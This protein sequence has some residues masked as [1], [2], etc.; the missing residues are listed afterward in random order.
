MHKYILKLSVVLCVCVIVG[1]HAYAQIDDFRSID[2]HK[3]DSMALLFPKYPL[4][5]LRVLAERL[6]GPL[7]TEPEKFRAIYKW[8]CYNID[9][10]YSLYLLN[11]RK[12]SRLSD[13]VELAEWNTKINA[14]VFKTLLN[15]HRTVCTGYAYLV[16]ELCYHAGI[17]SNIIHGFGRDAYGKEPIAQL[18][19]HSWNRVRLNGNWYLCDVTWS[20]GAMNPR[21]WEYVR[22]Y[23]DTY[24]LQAK[25]EFAKRHVE[26]E[27]VAGN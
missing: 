21:T 24:F 4:K 25:E 17:T 1:S 8:I 13:P 20:S 9:Y 12:R 27:V 26:T 3:A 7:Q 15:H 2:F 11:K 14:A 10:D 5:D 19:D 23:N 18:P 16:K 6:T 22:K